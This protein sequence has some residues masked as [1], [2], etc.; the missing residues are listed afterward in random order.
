MIALALFFGL[1]IFMSGSSFAAIHGRFAQ[2]LEIPG[3][4]AIP[5]IPW[6]TLA[7]YIL[8][9]IV[10]S[11]IKKSRIRWCSF[12]VASLVGNLLIAYP[13]VLLNRGSKV[14]TTEDPIARE[15]LA[16]FKARFPVL[17]TSYSGPSGHVIRVRNDQ[18]SQDMPRYLDQLT[19]E[20]PN[21]SEMAT[22]RK[23]SD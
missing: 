7:A 2:Q 15:D 16:T 20:K 14:I 17:V 1:I 18:Y 11:V 22:P 10:I 6:V 4:A 23:P 12:V 19:K 21:K 8:A 9:V 3:S 5:H 13:I